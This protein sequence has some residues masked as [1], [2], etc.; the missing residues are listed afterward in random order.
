MG[1]QVIGTINNDNLVGTIYQDVIYG[2][3]GNDSLNGLAGN[4]YLAGGLGNDT[5]TVDS[6]GDV[7]VEN[8]NEGTDTV[9]SSIT[10]TL[11]NNLENLTLSGTANINGTGNTLVN[12]IIGNS[13][14]NILDGGT[15]ADNLSG[16]LGDDTYVVDNIGDTVTEN[17]N[18]GTDTVISS[19]TYTLGNNLE[20][21]TLSGTANINGT[22]NTLSNIIT[23]NTGNNT[24]S[25][26][27]GGIDTLIGG[28]GDDT[29]IVTNSLDIITENAGEG[30]DLVRSSV[31]FVLAANVDNLTLTGT[32]NINGTGNTDANIITGNNGN[33]VLDDGGVGGSD[34]LSG[35]LGSDTYIVNNIGDLVVENPDNTSID[36]VRASVNFTLTANVENLTLTGTA[37]INGTGNTLANVIIGNSGDN[38]LND[39]G[40]GGIDTL[41]GG[42]GND[43]YIVNNIGDRITELANGGTDTVQTSLT[44]TLGANLENLTLTGIANVNGTGNTLANVI[45]GN[46]GNNILNDG[47]VGG[48][49]TLV[50]G[51]GND[52]YIVNNSSDIITEAVNAGTD[53]VQSSVNYVLGSNIENITLTG[54]ANTNATGNTLNNT[55]TGNTG[56]NI[57]NGGAGADTLNSGGGRGID[58]YQYSQVSDSIWGTNVNHLYDTITGYKVGDR[59]DATSFNGNRVLRSSVGSI[60]VTNTNP[61]TLARIQALLT[62]T[63]FAANSIVAFTTSGVG[64]GTFVAINDATAG[65]SATND[66]LVFLQGYNISAT[67]T[68][69][70]I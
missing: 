69:T 57:L 53:V 59:I 64:S 56:S 43:T 19:I 58:T 39:G 34:T 48:S 55:I 2:G 9:I 32:A 23:G 24:L 66:Q 49:D 16:G 15:G 65:F 27:G 1:N 28:L 4:D 10:Y 18:E 38:I 7:V 51:A 21:L 70:V 63:T 68:I 17:A 50:G 60:A 35:G 33:N 54:T 22:G 62:N 44:Y 37:N 40:V 41:T 6:V 26:G 42:A 52:T 12:V 61:L 29:Y 46:I 5:Y 45:T 20:N 13:G 31:N 47:G 14:N 67:N 36:L 3:A 30:T 8:T 11:G 25:D